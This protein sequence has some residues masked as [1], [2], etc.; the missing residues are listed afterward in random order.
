[1]RV[2][3]LALA[4]PYEPRLNEKLVQYVEHS[5]FEVIDQ[6]GLGLTLD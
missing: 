4:T 2:R 3:K 6:V 1:L 5:R